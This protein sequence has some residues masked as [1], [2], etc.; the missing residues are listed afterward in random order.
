MACVAAWVPGR[1]RQR[2][3]AAAWVA[4]GL[5]TAQLHVMRPLFHQQCMTGSKSLHALCRLLQHAGCAEPGKGKAHSMGTLHQ[6][7]PCCSGRR[8]TWYGALGGSA[9]AGTWCCL[10]KHRMW[11][12]LVLHSSTLHVRRPPTRGAAPGV[13]LLRSGQLQASCCAMLLM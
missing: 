9:H 10:A 5:H 6:L 8:V 13:V 1:A 12:M 7:A 4:C 11:F 3:S 2:T